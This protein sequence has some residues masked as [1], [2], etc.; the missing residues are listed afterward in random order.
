[1]FFPY[2]TILHLQ[3]TVDKKYRAQEHFAPVVGYKEKMREKDHVAWN[4]GD[5]YRQKNL[6]CLDCKKA[7]CGKCGVECPG[8]GKEGL[9]WLC[10]ICS[11]SRQEPDQTFS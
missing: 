4:N 10:K 9:V 2:R 7:V 8:I 3:C 1:M 5:L 11:E 6:L